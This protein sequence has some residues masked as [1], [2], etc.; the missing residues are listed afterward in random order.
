MYTY[1]KSTSYVITAYLTLFLNDNIINIKYQF[2]YLKIY[3]YNI[4]IS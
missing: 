3:I 2:L 4:V 1:P